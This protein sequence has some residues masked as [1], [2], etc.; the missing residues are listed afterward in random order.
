MRPCLQTLQIAHSLDS[1]SSFNFDKI[2]FET[3]VEAAILTRPWFTR[4]WVLQELV[5][6]QD[7]WIQIGSTRIRWDRFCV[8]VLS[9]NHPIWR[10][11]SRNGLLAI[12]EAQ[13]KF[14]RG[15]EDPPRGQSITENESAGE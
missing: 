13:S 1:I 14:R 10:N 6:S 4:T 9:G 3:T 7:P 5:L 11:D 2:A 15:H 8:P 12:H